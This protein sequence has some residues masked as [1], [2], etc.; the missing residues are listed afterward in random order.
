M[1]THARVV[2]VG[3]GCVGANML[4]SLAKRGWRD[5]VLLE[6]TELTAGSTWHAAGLLPLYSFS[7]SFGRIIVKTLEIYEGLE[8]ETGQAV[9]FHKCGQL[10]VANTPERMDEY[11]NYASIAETQGVRAEILGPAEVKALWPLMEPGSDLI[12]AVYNPDDGH[13]A[14]ADVTQA[15]AKGARDMGATIYRNTQVTGFEQLANGEWKVKTSQGDIICEHVITATGNYVQQTAKMIGQ[16]LPAIPIVHQYWVTEPVPEVQERQ[17]QGLPEMPV[18]RNE[19]INGY[20]RE[21]RNGLMFGPYERPDQLEHF[22]YDGVPEWF[23]ADL[24]PEDF[25]AVEDNWTAAVELVPALGQVGIKNNV[26][27]PICTT[28]DNLPLVGP[29]LGKRNFWLAEGFSGGILMPGGLGHYLAEWIV[30]GEPSIDLSEV[31]ARRFGPYANKRWSSEKIR[32]AFG[33]N[34]GLHYPG[35]EWPAARRVKMAPCYDRLD[36]ERA[37]WGAVYGWEVPLWFAPEGTEARDVWSYREFNSKEHVGNEC[38]AIRDGVGLIEMTPMA[39]FEVSGPGAEAWLDRILANRVPRKVGGMSLCHLLTHKGTVRS[40]FTVTRLDEELFY[41]V[42]TPRGERHDFDVLTRHLPEEGGVALRNVTL[43]RGCFTVVGPAARDVL[44]Q[45]TD[46]DLS[47]QEFP[48]MQAR[49][50]AVGLASDVRLLRVNYEGELGWELYHPI[51]HN[52]HLYD[53]IMAAGQA[54]DITLAGYRAIESLRLEKSYRAIYRDLNVEYS[55]LESG[56]DRFLRFDKADFI[57]KAALEAQ[58]AAGLTRRIVT[59]KVETVDGDAYMNEGVYSNGSLVGRVTSGAHSHHFG[60]CISMAYLAAEHAAEGA[61]LEIPILGERRKAT[62]IAD[63]P[64]D[65]GNQR[66]RM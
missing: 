26:R 50:G 57:G 53:Q 11:L 1:K 46:L 65:P 16:A 49:V 42:G 54:H 12:G 37:V 8:A 31:D 62:V 43:E 9:G 58:Q 56:L 63:S 25:D 44:Q 36:K 60:H 19:A 45:I 21:E 5:V 3:G 35:Y 64:Y 28:P 17:A 29:A 66:P 7:Y 6:R 13:I 2:I 38:R 18:L 27:G 23:G 22:A 32:E 24:M 4:Y 10:R 15:L 41:L 40:E 30:E 59:L 33:H 48:W 20:V 61:E 39:K 14:P 52:L 55:A 47:N 34:F 51:C